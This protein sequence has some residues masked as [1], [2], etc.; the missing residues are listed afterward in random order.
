MKCVTIPFLENYRITK[1]GEIFTE[2]G[3]KKLPTYF[4]KY[5][6]VDIDGILYRVDELLLRTYIGIVDLPI[7]YKD[8]NKHNCTLDNIEYSVTE[9][10]IVDEYLYIKNSIMI[11]KKIPDSNDCYVSKN[12]VVF[13]TYKRYF[14]PISHADNGYSKVSLTIGSICKSR[15]LHR[16]VY[17][18]WVQ[19]IEERLVIDHIDG[20]KWHN[21]ISNLEMVT[22]AENNIRAF[23]TNLKKLKYTKDIIGII[24]RMMQ[25]QVQINTMYN[26]FEITTPKEKQLFTKMISDIKHFKCHADVAKNYDVAN[27]NSKQQNHFT[28]LTDERKRV[29]EAL[30][31]E[32][33]SQQ[34]IA[35][36]IGIS[37]GVVENY[38]HELAKAS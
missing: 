32:G 18:T 29:I 25:E 9:F 24:C 7:M 17:S 2:D 20:K 30:L 37:R 34:K 22:S 27:Y 36:L 31:K 3:S 26:V 28:V 35:D 38:S 4:R 13:S 12:G 33:W 5:K 8:L 21:D 10:D 15:L 16:I 11:F 6:M 1:D 23:Q 14:K 19:E